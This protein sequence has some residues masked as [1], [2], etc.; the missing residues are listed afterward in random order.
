[1]PE[2]IALVTCADFPTGY[3]E[4]A[5]E[6]GLERAGQP[7]EWAVWDDASVD[8][9]RFGLVVVRSTWD[10]TERLD[11]FLGWVAEV[12]AVAAMV[13][14]ARVVAW[15]AHKR[16]LLELES[17]GVAIVPTELVG[18]AD[19]VDVAGVVDRRAWSDGV[20]V[21]PAVSAGARGL[22]HW[23]TDGA[24]L[25]AAQGAVDVLRR[26]RHDVLLQPLLGSIAAAG[27]ISVM[28]IGGEPTHAVRKVPADG[29]IRSQPHLGGQVT[30][31]TPT[32]EH[33]ALGRAAIAAAAEVCSIATSEL[34]VAR[35]DCVEVAGEP[36][37]M[38][39]ELIEPY[40]FLP[41]ASEAGERLAAELVA[42]ATR[43][44]RPR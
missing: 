28:F 4:E 40:L 11:A 42:A 9:S 18:A 27:E 1:M 15:N 23:P 24:G 2:P 14:P 16:Y 5:L 8:W 6:R 29:D 12:D 10:Y 26:D 25:L 34:V 13:S 20:V 21:K 36:R 30:A 32:D 17:R 19:P 39:L 33:L 35:V 7:Y 22:S 41:F 44:A 3:D 31:V 43:A 37:L 38:E